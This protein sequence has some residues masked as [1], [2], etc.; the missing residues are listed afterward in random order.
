MAGDTAC[1]TSLECEVVR[2]GAD[3]KCRRKQSGTARVICVELVLHPC[4]RSD[5]GQAVG[6]R[7]GDLA[8]RRARAVARSRRR[9]GFEQDVTSRFEAADL[10][11]AAADD[12]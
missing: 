1:E 4:M 9:T 11:G 10:F 5:S 12:P 2:A 7:R 6:D 8:A 3:S